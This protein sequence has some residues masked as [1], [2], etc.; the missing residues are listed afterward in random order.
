MVKNKLNIKVMDLVK[1]KE[2]ILKE[3]RI[4]KLGKGDTPILYRLQNHL[5]N[6]DGNWSV[7]S[8][9][10][11]T[12]MDVEFY[13]SMVYQIVYPAKKK[14]LLNIFLDNNEIVGKTTRQKI[15]NLVI[16][17]GSNKI[18]MLKN[19]GR[20]VY[21]KDILKTKENSYK[22]ISDSYVFDTSFGGV[23]TTSSIQSFIQE[24]KNQL[25]LNI[26]FKYEETY[27]YN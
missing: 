21:K 8:I 1:F 14:L 24:I 26:E 11:K 12:N 15:Q 20:F 19:N 7:N 17:I 10:Q 3:L 23:G 22:D 18:S 5:N 25:K 13:A 16:K 6:L 4:R 27:S 9:L 2:D